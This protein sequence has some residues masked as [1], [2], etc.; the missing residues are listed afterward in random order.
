VRALAR[1]EGGGLLLGEASRRWLAELDK[2]VL[3]ADSDSVAESMLRA[4]LGDEGW[5]GLPEVVQRVSR[6]TG[7]QSSRSTAAA[8]STRPSSS[9]RRLR[10]RPSS[11]RPSAHRPSSP[12]RPRS[13]P[14]RS[15]PHGSR[16]S[17]VGT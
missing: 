14:R 6:R 11:S 12:S 4:V 15:R 16:A 3:A 9:S 2:I 13:S 10:S 5:E 17:A 7:R 1:L 8:S